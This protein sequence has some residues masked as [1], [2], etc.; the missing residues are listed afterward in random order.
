MMWQ[1]ASTSEERARV[2]SVEHKQNHNTTAICRA[3]ANHEYIPQS[4]VLQEHSMAR[5][6]AGG[7]QREEGMVQKGPCTDLRK[8]MP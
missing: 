4:Y 6:I 1:S 7:L 8:R 3:Q 5:I 2:T